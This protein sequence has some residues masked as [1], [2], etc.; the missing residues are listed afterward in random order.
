MKTILS[1]LLA[2]VA[3]LAGLRADEFLPGVKRIL[4]L[5]DSITYSGE[6]VDEFEAFL[7]TQFPSREFTVINCGLP[8]ETVSGLSE[9][10]HAGGSFPRPYLDERLDRV[11]ALV[12]P[13]LVFACYGMNC[14]IYLP[15]DEGRFAKFREGIEKLRAKVKAAGA[16]MIHLTPAVFDPVPLKSRAIPADRVKDGQMFEGYDDVLTRYSEWLV[17]QKANGW[18]V[19]DTHKA[20]RAALDAKRATDPAYKF[21]ADGVHANAEGHHVMAAAVLAELAPEKAAKFH[22]EDAALHPLL[23]AVRARG[24]ILA[25]SYLT[26]AGHKRHG[27]A[28][29]LPVADAVAKAAAM[30]QTIHASM[31][32]EP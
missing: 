19:V 23:K 7:I 21:A 18:R 29:G 1:A 32:K 13:D 3:S 4:F 15:F 12:K 22:A 26:T 17:S 5:G 27:M 31:P 30:T 24:R 20:M 11:L 9:A 6:Y 8:S 28:K 10:G 14:G 16:Q 2:L 25:D